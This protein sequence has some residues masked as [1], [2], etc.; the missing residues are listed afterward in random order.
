MRK[1]L[2]GG[3]KVLV[4]ISVVFLAASVALSTLN[5]ISRS[6]FLTS[7]PWIE[8]L[9]CYLA[10]L[11]MFLMMPY[12]EFTDDQLSISFLDEKFKNNQTARKIL[13]YIRGFFTVLFNG[14]LIRAGFRVVERNL[15]LGSASPVMKIPYGGLYTV[16]LAALVLVIV[17]WAFHIFIN[18][19][20]GKPHV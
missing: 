12:L 19:W 8:E 15:N 18:E 3:L 9:C 6:F 13:F 1:I 2:D 11:V 7:F 5:A 14:I 20:R 10:G 17:Y 4:A 16:V